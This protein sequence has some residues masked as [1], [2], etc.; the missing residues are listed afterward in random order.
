[1][2]HDIVTTKPTTLDDLKNE[3][4]PWGPIGETVYRR[5]YSQ[6]K[7]DGQKEIWPETAIRAVDG[8]LGLVPEEFIEPDEREKLIN[9]LFPFGALPAGRHL[10]AS[11]MKGRQF[12]FNCHAAGWDAKEPQAHFTF[13]FDSLMQ[14]GGVG[15]NYSNRYLRALPPIQR[16]IDLHIVCD[17]KHP[18]I[19]EFNDLLC[20]VMSGEPLS[21]DN[22]FDVP[23]SRE[24]WV[25]VVNFVMKTSWDALDNWNDDERRIVI[26][27]SGIRQRGAPLRTSGGIACGPGPL[28]KMLSN[29]VGYLNGCFGRRLSSND[30]MII[31]HI[32]ADCVVA[33]GKRRSSRMSIKNWKDH[34]IFEF[35]N[36]KKIDGAHWT[37]NISVEVDKEFREAYNYGDAQARAVMR[38]IVLGKRTNGEPGMWDIDEARRGEREPEKMFSPNPCGEICLQMWENCNLGHINLEYFAMRPSFQMLEAFRLMTRWL[39]RATFG[40]IPNSRQREVVNRNRRISVGFF[41]FH[42]LLSLRGI[43][44]SDAWKDATVIKMLV[45]ARKVVQAEA[46]KYATQLD[47]PIPVKNTGLAPTGS[48]AALPG[49]STSAQTIEDPYFIRRVRY[50]NTDLELVVK[51]SEGHNWYPDPDAQDTTIVEY[52]CENPLIAKVKSVGLDPGIVE[53]QKQVSVENYIQMQAMLQECYADN[54][55]S[56]TIPLAESNMPT[57]DEMERLLVA[58]LGRVKGT[59]MYPDRSRKNSPFESLTKEQFEQYQGPK[60]IAQVE[61]VCKTGCPAF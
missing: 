28:V 56:F 58:A 48:T 34:D 23:D 8:N 57:E 37:T 22:K 49:T 53:G 46:P 15:S 51:R 26:D 25:D 43:K 21:H 36:C 40:D 3:R 17:S 7:E 31:D 16:R 13:L 55:I 5:T 20:A 2:P 12:L 45:D 35:I 54:A 4:I 24:G 30:A 14:G 32:L 19:N 47:I 33:G 10:N 27:V 60:Q 9:L 6:T 11:G 59:T 41:G 42:G 18:N 50:A 39:I 52:W 38:A 61:D 44:Y 29:L 1:M